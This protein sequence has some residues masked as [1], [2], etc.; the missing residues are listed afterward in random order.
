MYWMSGFESTYIFGSGSDVLDHTC[1]RHNWRA[2]LDSV[3]ESG[4]HTLRYP[5]PWHKIE[6]IRG[7]YDWQWMDGVMEHMHKI[8][9][10][11]ILDPLH[12]TSFPEWLQGGFLH[13]NFIESYRAFLNALAARYP[14]V[15]RYTPVNEPMLTALFCGRLGIWHPQGRKNSTF[16]R[17]LLNLGR[18]YAIVTEDLRR[19]ND[20]TEIIYIGTCEHHASLHPGSDRLVRFLNLRRFMMLDLLLREVDPSLVPLFHRAGIEDSELEWFRE[21]RTR[22]DVLGLDYYAHS[23]KEWTRGRVRHV[24]E[25]PRGFASVAQDYVARYRLPIMLGETNLRGLVTDR[26]MWLKIM[27]QQC[28]KLERQGVDI[29]GAC[30]FPWVDSTDWDTLVTRVSNHV[31]PV[32]IYWLDERRERH[33]SEL[34]RGFQELAQGRRTWRGLP[35]HDFQEPWRGRLDKHVEFLVA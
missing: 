19:R 12:H 24:S 2:D 4:V 32:G 34:V 6:A 20:Q 29:R 30:W 8:G 9:L 15:R 1:H 21:H 5:A 14:W 26:L 16:L 27:A 10:D 7:R 35:S 25:Q 17:M 13:P 33:S 22:I 11:P 31:D 18:V 23:E 28:E 3:R